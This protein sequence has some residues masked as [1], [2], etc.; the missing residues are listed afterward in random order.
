LKHREIGVNVVELAFAQLM[1]FVQLFQTLY[2]RESVEQLV[3]IALAQFSSP[4]QK[5]SGPSM[6]QVSMVAAFLE[7]MAQVEPD[8]WSEGSASLGW[9]ECAHFPKPSTHSAQVD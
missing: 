5:H 4:A 6:S 8:S 1:A 9:L 7:Y 3:W 2:E